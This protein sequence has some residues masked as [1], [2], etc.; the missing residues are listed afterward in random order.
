MSK[1]TAPR[2]SRVVAA[3]PPSNDVAASMTNVPS[4]IQVEQADV[5]VIDVVKR[6]RPIDNE[7]VARLAESIRAIGLR[8]PITVRYFA[9]RKSADGTTHDSY[10]LVAGAHRL[11][12]V[13]SLGWEKID[14]IVVGDDAIDA[15]LWEIAENLHR[16][17]LTVLERDT[18]VARWIELRTAKQIEAD[19]ASQVATHKHKKRGQQPGGV[20]AASRELGISK[21]DAHRAIKVA[22]LS[23]EAKQAARDAGLDDNRTALLEVAKETTPEAQVARVAALKNKKTET[24]QKAAAPDLPTGSDVDAAKVAELAR[25]LINYLSGM[26]PIL[27]EILEIGESEFWKQITSKETRKE[28]GIVL[29]GRWR[30]GAIERAYEKL[31]KRGAIYQHDFADQDDEI[32]VGRDAE[33]DDNAGPSAAAADTSAQPTST[34]AEPGSAEW[35]AERIS[36][37]RRWQDEVSAQ[38]HPTPRKIGQ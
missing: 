26:A 8:T 9:D 27:E 16:A 33:W 17:E 6:L 29:D 1:A 12:A 3:D 36:T 25:G 21:D 38:P 23:D 20:N 4:Q 5:D 19:N 22:S 13:K 30:L 24:P 11:A 37:L 31:Q 32:H 10:V 18:Q 15:E 7:T 34:T 2:E 28:L 35:K 14:C